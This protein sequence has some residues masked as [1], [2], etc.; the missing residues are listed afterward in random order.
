MRK[1]ET[2]PCPDCGTEFDSKWARTAHEKSCPVKQSLELRRLQ[3]QLEWRRLRIE[4]WLGESYRSVA[5]S[6]AAYHNGEVESGQRMHQWFAEDFQDQVRNLEALGDALSQANKT[7]FPRL[8]KLRSDVALLVEQA[9]E[10][11]SILATLN[12]DYGAR[13]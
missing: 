6:F 1:S 9:Q 10:L 12:R 11:A 5:R 2:Y 3:E 13:P 8:N 4:R 7:H